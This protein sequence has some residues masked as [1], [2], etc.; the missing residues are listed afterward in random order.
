MFLFIEEEK[1]QDN[2]CVPVAFLIYFRK[3]T[4]SGIEIKICITEH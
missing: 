2:D 4:I 3:D 1:V